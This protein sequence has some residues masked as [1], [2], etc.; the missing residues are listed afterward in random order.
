MKNF[1]PR[2][3]QEDIVMQELLDE[4]LIYDMKTDKA[5][6]LNQ[7]SALIWQEC[8]GNKSIQK[9]TRSVS[10]KLNVS[11]EEDFVRLALNDL[12]KEN[13]I[14]NSRTTIPLLDTIERRALLKKIGLASIA[15]LPVVSSIVAPRSIAAQ[16]VATCARTTEIC[17]LEITTA[18]PC[19]NST[20]QCLEASSTSEFRCFPSVGQA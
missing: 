9:I 7:T 18:F 13:L 14:D 20:D 15:A 3:R 6:C 11:I 12:I 16:S 4:V 2:S 8:D 17:S 10:R 1:F 5:F 19:C